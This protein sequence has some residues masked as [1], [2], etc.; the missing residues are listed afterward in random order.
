[1]NFALL[2]MSGRRFRDRQVLAPELVAEM[3]TVHAEQYTSL[4]M[5]VGLTFFVGTDKGTRRLKH[6][7]NISTFSSLFEVAPD[8]G[9]A[10]VIL[11]N[12]YC[13]DFPDESIMAGIF[14]QILDLPSKKPFA[15]SAIEPER[16]LWPGYTGAYLGEG[17]VVVT[18]G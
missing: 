12:R 9:A 7:G 18:V 3:Q 8:A 17:A 16:S 6:A 2:H 14:D 11:V 15:P 10:V 5:N 1:A 4:D 13:P